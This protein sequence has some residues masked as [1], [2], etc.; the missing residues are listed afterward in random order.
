MNLQGLF[1]DL[2]LSRFIAEYLHR[3][4]TARAGT[5]FAVQ[6]LGSWDALAAIL[7][8]GD[9]DVLIVGQGRRRDE[10]PPATIEAA[11]DLCGRGATLLVRHAERC[12]AGIAAL[13]AEFAGAFRAPVD[14][15]MYV[16]PPGQ[17]GFSWHYDAEDVFILQTAGEKRYQLRK[18][19]V[20]P[21]PLEETLPTDMHYEREIMPLLE[22][23]LKAGD[24]LYIPC[25]YWHR[26]DC[27]HA[28]EVAISLAVGVMSR[29]ALDWY[30]ALRPRLAQSLAWRRRLPLPV[31]GS[32]AAARDHAVAFDQLA[33]ELAEDFA[34]V[35]SSA[36]AEN[37][38][39]GLFDER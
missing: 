9:A 20:H 28:S 31:D 23:Q 16:T 25:G 1:G 33:K 37:A 6:P 35:L 14:V 29:S 18:N 22:V 12:H 10:P 5:T 24:F 17:H 8:H 3:L 26:A 2:S 19:T 30:D 4:P 11:H 27:T 34:R 7:A 13:A 38:F 36:A 39:P 21:W 15:H 32:A